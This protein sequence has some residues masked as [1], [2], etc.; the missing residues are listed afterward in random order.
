[1]TVLGQFPLADR[2]WSLAAS[3]L[4]SCLR[5]SVAGLT[6]AEAQFR[7]ELSGENR[8][9]S[10]S[11][12]SWLSALKFRL[13][14]PLT[15]LL[16]FA[17][18]V[19][20]A[21]G[22]A[23]QAAL[24]AL[25]ILLSTLLDL[26]QESR[27]LTAA[28]RLKSTVALTSR[29]FRDG[30]LQ[31]IAATGLVPGDIVALG[32]GDLVPADGVL[33]EATDFFVNEAPLTGESIPVQKKSTP[34]QGAV[35][36]EGSNRV[37]LGSSVLSGVA[38]FLVCRTGRSTEL[39]ALSHALTAPTPPSA[40][41]LA[42]RSLSSSLARLAMVLI[43]LT[44][45]INLA[46][47]RPWLS[48]ALFAVALAVGVTPELLPM[49]LSVA[50]AKGA[51]RMS[52]KKIV[53]KRLSAIEDLG[54]MTVLCTDKTG[55][56]TEAEV[57]LERWIDTAGQPS[58]RVLELAALNT[59]FHGG[60]RNSLDRAILQRGIANVA[61]WTKIA[62]IPFDFVRRR[63]TT[64]LKGKEESLLITKGA[65][66][67]VLECCSHLR[68]AG[69]LRALS[70]SD[71]E[72]LLHLADDWAAAG[73]RVMAVAFKRV[74]K[75]WPLREEGLSLAGFLVF[76][77]PPKPSARPALHAITRSGVAV[78][79]VTG[80]HASVARYL[81]QLV[82]LPVEGVLLG[83]QIEEMSDRA[84][85][86]AA[87]GTTLFCR[88]SPEQKN[89]VILALKRR[90]EV[91]GF[92]GDGIND[93]AALRSADIGL[94]VPS[95]TDVAREAADVLLLEK[96][97]I[98]IHQAILE[99]RRTFANVVKYLLMTTSANVGN[100][101]SLAVATLL[102]PYLPLLPLQ[103]LLNNVLSDVSEL[104]LPMDRVERKSLIKPHHWD[105][106]AIRSF[107]LVAGPISAFF[108]LLLL[109]LLLGLFHASETAFHTAWFVQT[110]MTQIL[111]MFVLRTCG[112][113]LRSRP[114]PLLTAMGLGVLMVGVSLPYSPLAHLLGFTPLSPAL[115]GML[116]ANSGLYLLCIE[117]LKRWAYRRLFG[118]PSQSAMDR[119]GEVLKRPEQRPAEAR[120][121]R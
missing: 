22:D 20:A 111:V 7:G 57:A 99:G 115:I 2:Y 55:T 29:V 97:L 5:S 31:V 56:L 63:A 109:P 76:F 49:V 73:F 50:L 79:V 51:L 11:D 26:T 94:S 71:R 110:L 41:E 60:I 36:P 74:E 85:E 46:L 47:G 100:V 37:L 77:D 6:Q 69:L 21:M 18:L 61:E 23:V 82:D 116:I 10:P 45:V 12:H 1:V 65:P 95:A 104:P 84:L 54:A 108:D 89:R 75:N 119:A 28:S 58:A 48:S 78:K 120:P 44:L 33:L 15:H 43:P 24:I 105:I 32:P 103:I 35:E 121:Q 117:A 102:L 112:N 87:L 80:D 107:M 81:C 98:L 106:A 88:V 118:I 113:P 25:I 62:E 67:G 40:F 13:Q 34:E 83:G 16:L 39:G 38:H 30:S 72:Q 92:L 14:N 64:F 27:A 91:V 93:A 17:A 42:V 96:N 66:E 86:S 70:G 68:E 52:K 19:S 53:I 59:H 4:L 8:L 9:D 114:H 101:M 90:G 3:E